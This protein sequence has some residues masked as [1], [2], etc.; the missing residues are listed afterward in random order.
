MRTLFPGSGVSAVFPL[1]GMGG[2]VP[3]AGDLGVLSRL[4]EEYGSDRWTLRFRLLARGAPDRRELVCD[5]PVAVHRSEPRS[6]VSR[7]TGRKAS[8]VFRRL[9]DGPGLSLWE[10]RT[11]FLRPDQIRLHAAESGIR[12]AGESVYARE[13]PVSR[14]DLPGG[15]RPGGRSFVLL[16]GPAVHL[17][18]LEIP[19][20]DQGRFRSPPPKVMAKWI[21]AYLKEEKDLQSREDWLF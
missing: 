11:S 13:D 9:L 15:R 4:R 16:E 12:I 3:F 1:A 18:G 20:L 14:S 21:S 7:R 8:T 6:L 2:A 5:L 17:A 19:S 10:A